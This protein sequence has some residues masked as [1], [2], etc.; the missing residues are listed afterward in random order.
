MADLFPDDVTNRL[1]RNH[2]Y[3]IDFHKQFIHAQHTMI[4]NCQMA[5]KMV[6]I[7]G[8]RRVNQVY[9]EIT[10]KSKTLDCFL[11]VSIAIHI[12]RD[13]KELIEE[14]EE[15]YI[16]IFTVA[17]RCD[18]CHQITQMHNQALEV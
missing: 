8:D 9:S 17:Q 6:R 15:D 2:E 4:N 12:E 11:H 3:I 10:W 18:N 16:A 1:K 13:W 7:T 14:L 5:S